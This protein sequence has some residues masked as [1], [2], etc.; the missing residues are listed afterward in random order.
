MTT[1]LIVDCVLMRVSVG[2]EARWGGEEV[3]EGADVDCWVKYRDRE[4]SG[5]RWG[6]GSNGGN[7]SCDDGRG[8]VLEGDV[9]KQDVVDQVICELK[10][11]PTVLVEWGEEGV[12]LCLGKA[13]DVG[14]G[15]FSELFEVELGGGTKC[16][17]SGLRSRW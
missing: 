2:R 3:F 11:A 10:V 6:G 8:N 4:R 7:G 17:L 9:L 14:G 12:K 13:D 15:F 5:C 1:L 16:L